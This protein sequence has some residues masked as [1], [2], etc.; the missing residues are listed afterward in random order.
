ML[1]MPDNELSIVV[2]AF[3]RLVSD[4]I[5]CTL[6]AL[7]TVRTHSSSQPYFQGAAAT[8][9]RLWYH[10]QCQLQIGNM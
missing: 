5:L 6:S 10:F 2:R 8:M 9:L 3:L 1:L 4:S 7:N